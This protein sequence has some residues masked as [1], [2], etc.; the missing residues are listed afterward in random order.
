MWYAV[1]LFWVAL[2]AGIFWAYGRRRRRSGLAREKEIGTLIAEARTVVRAPESVAAAGVSPP[3]VPKVAPAVTASRRARLLGQRETLLYLLFRAGLPDHEIFANL[4]LSDVLEPAT[5]L[6]GFEREQLARR[7]AQQRLDLVVCNKQLEIVAVIIARVEEGETAFAAS[8][9]AAAGV[10]V[11]RI[12]PAA[13]PRH[14]QLRTLVY[15]EL[16]AG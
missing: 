7:F 8:S 3:A 15:D 9:L 14:A 6:P 13:P 12:D 16:T 11:V 4:A 1:A 2:V 10:R 5:G